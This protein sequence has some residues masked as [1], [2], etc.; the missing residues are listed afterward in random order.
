MPLD[1]SI[2]LQA[3]QGVTPL[4]NPLDLGMK[5]QGLANAMSQNKLIEANTAQ[6][7]QQ[8]AQ[9][10]ADDA[11]KRIAEWRALPD[12]LRT[13]ATAR[14]VVM[15]NV[16][17]G[18]TSPQAAS[19]ALDAINAT[20]DQ[21]ALDKLADGA[22]AHIPLGMTMDQYANMQV[23]RGLSGADKAGQILGQNQMIN[24]GQ[25]Q[26][27]NRVASPL[28]GAMNPNIPGMVPQSGGVPIY[29]SRGELAS[30]TT[31]PVGPKGEP[32][33]VPLSTVTPPHLAGPA[34]TPL[35]NGRFQVPPALRNPA[36]PAASGGQVTTGLGPAQT[37]AQSATGAQSAGKFS[38]IVDSGQQAQSQDAILA[39]MQADAAQFTTGYG[40]DKIKTFKQAV[41]RVMGPNGARVFGV[42]PKALESNES[43]D[44]LAA[45]IADGQGAGS[46]AR[47]AVKQAGSPNSHT[48]PPGVDMILRQLRGN[49]DY[50]RARSKL[51]AGWGDQSDRAG[52]EDN[53]GANLDPRAF[54]IARLAPEN[55]GTFLKSQTDAPV[56]IKAYRW[57]E[58]RGLLHGQ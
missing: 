18:A 23:A 16:Q 41:T 54:Q 25:T 5:Y 29:P 24:D 15:W 12:H 46:D 40:A 20:K 32:T 6:T 56:V 21:P 26:Q 7:K 39:N 45:Q 22:T 48:T 8:T 27:I 38:D 34:A 43:F 30:R 4:Q 10:G 17:S 49:S 9:S 11:A 14:Q 2:S 31:G 28:Q 53:V 36:N 47:L 52:F 50:I 57:A 51:A 1:P 13:Q 37:A 33:T 44:K 35:G 19:A 42:D 55:R 3:G 58:Q